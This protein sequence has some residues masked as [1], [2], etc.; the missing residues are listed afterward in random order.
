MAKMRDCIPIGDT[1]AIVKQPYNS[2]SNWTFIMLNL[3]IQEDTKSQQKQKKAV[4][5]ISIS[6]DRRAVKHHREHQGM[7]Q[8]K[9]D[10]LWCTGRF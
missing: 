3:P 8:A 1:M 10:M 7:I 5:P 4:D 2:D 6:R 9:V